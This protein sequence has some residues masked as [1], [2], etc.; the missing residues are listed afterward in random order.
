MHT[1]RPGIGTQKSKRILLVAVAALIFLSVC[2]SAIEIAALAGHDCTCTCGGLLGIGCTCGSCHSCTVLSTAS[3]LIRAAF[4]CAAALAAGVA[5]RIAFIC[6]ADEPVTHRT[7][8]LIWLK[9][10]LSD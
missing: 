1:V 9:V 3:M 5:G 4:I 6:S 8:S 10:K 7:R 2:A